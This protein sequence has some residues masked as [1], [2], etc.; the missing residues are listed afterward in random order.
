MVPPEEFLTLIESRTLSRLSD[1]QLERLLRLL[2]FEAYLRDCRQWR[3]VSQLADEL[4]DR[5]RYPPTAEAPPRP[6]PPPRR[7]PR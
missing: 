3:A 2:G 1:E 6:D 4:N 7:R 5:R